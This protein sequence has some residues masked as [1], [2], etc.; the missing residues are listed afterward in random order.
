MF[1]VDVYSEIRSH[2]NW[3][4][5]ILE[6]R[7]VMDPLYFR[8]NESKTCE[9]MNQDSKPDWIGLD[10]TE[11]DNHPAG[12]PVGRTWLT[13]DM[14]ALGK[15]VAAVKRLIGSQVKLVAVVKG[16]AYGLGDAPG[17]ARVA[18]KHGADFLGVELLNEAVELRRAGLRAPILMFGPVGSDDAKTILELGIEVT[19]RDHKTLNRIVDLSSSLERI[20]TLHLEYETG[21][22]RFGNTKLEVLSLARA[23]NNSRWVGLG[24][25]WSHFISIASGDTQQSRS[26]YRTYLSLIEELQ[27]LGISPG[28]LHICNSGATLRYRDMHLDMVRCGKL[29][30]GMVPAPDLIDVLPLKPVISWKTRIHWIRRVKQGDGVSYGSTWIA[31]KDTSIGIANMGFGDGYSSRLSSRSNV[32][33]HGQYVPLVGKINM[34]AIMFDLSNVPHASIGDEV[35]MIGEQNGKAITINDIAMRAN[36]VP[37]EFLLGIDTRVERITI[38]QG[39]SGP[40]ARDDLM[41]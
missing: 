27:R 20:A 28:R 8:E 13:K 34:S 24:G 10:W 18:L 19:V 21:L 2:I 22:N 4:D 39:D 25:V 3:L 37:A 16:R 12:D 17:V 40:E 26:Q 38:N 33:I 7:Q 5:C 32:L 36:S 30:Y 6:E 1:K 11:L 31:Q 14:A 9:K 41:N 23:I 15:N 29:I 35:V